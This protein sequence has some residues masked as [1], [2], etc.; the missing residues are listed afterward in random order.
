MLAVGDGERVVVDE[1]DERGRP[2]TLRGPTQA[3]ASTLA[4]AR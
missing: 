3:Q 4:A 2:R 1:K